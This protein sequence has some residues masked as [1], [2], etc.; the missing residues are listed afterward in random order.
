MDYTR[1]LCDALRAVKDEGRYRVFADI[2]RHRGSFPRATFHTP[3]GTRDIV[4]WCSNDYL[5]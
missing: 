2:V 3:E 1:K 5:G 4:V